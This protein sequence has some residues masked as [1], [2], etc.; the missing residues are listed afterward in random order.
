MV[1]DDERRPAVRVG[2]AAVAASIRLVRLDQLGGYRMTQ[3]L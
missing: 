1:D 2:S 3:R